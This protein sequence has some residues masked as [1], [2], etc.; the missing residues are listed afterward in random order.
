MRAMRQSL[1]QAI[2]WG[3]IVRNPARL[4]GTLAYPKRAEIVPFTKAEVDL[5]CDE[6]DAHNA[7]LVRF[8]AATGMRPCEFLALEWRDIKRNDEGLHVAALVERTF[9]RGEAR[10]YGKTARSRRRVPLSSYAQ[11]ALAS[12][13]RRIDT[14]L[15][16]PAPT[17]EHI[18]LNNWNL[19]EWK[20]AL[21]SSGV[22]HGTPYVLRHTFATSAIAAGIGLFELSRFMGTSVKQLDATYGHLI[23]GA[24]D[25]ARA[26][27]D[28]LGFGT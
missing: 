10:L 3:V 16:F 6:L 5:I 12:V 11:A 18:H 14:P 28:A 26:K 8:A 21:E 1:D 13:T 7:A 4:A 17:G 9:S 2:A 15:I 23:P 22:G 25:A 24:E 27:L 20:P 19:G